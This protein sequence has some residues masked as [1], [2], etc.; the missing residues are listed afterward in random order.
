VPPAEA[1]AERRHLDTVDRLVD[2]HVKDQPAGKVW[3]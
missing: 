3:I 1:P 2:V